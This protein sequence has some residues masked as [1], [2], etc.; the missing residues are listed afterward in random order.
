MPRVLGLRFLGLSCF[1][2]S[3]SGLGTITTGDIREASPRFSAKKVVCGQ[4]VPRAQK[5]PNIVAE[6]KEW[7]AVQRAGLK[8][9]TV[10]KAEASLRLIVST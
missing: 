5:T 8:S 3:F 7:L 4:N 1:F 6:H 10:S 2:Q 9:E